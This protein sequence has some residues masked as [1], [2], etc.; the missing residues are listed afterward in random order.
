MDPAGNFAASGEL[1]IEFTEL[2][3]C[4]P[5]PSE[6]DVVFNKRDPKH[7]ADRVLSVLR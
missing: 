5:V 6:Q 3:L 1:V 2:F 7:W 4:Q